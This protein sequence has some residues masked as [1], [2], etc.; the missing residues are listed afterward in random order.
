M[1]ASSV[2]FQ[3]AKGPFR[4]AARKTG[5][6]L[7]RIVSITVAAKHILNLSAA[8][9]E[10]VQETLVEIG[11]T[12][13]GKTIAQRKVKGSEPPIEAGE[14]RGKRLAWPINGDVDVKV[15]DPIVRAHGEVLS[16]GTRSLSRSRKQTG[17]EG[18]G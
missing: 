4:A 15:E 3:T 1:E 14:T 9:A 13:R 6:L 7:R 5:Q 8:E 12:V 16:A 18:W 2:S 10:V 17:D 11:K